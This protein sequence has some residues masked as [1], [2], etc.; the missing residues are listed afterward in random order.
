MVA[1]LAKRVKLGIGKF[2]YGVDFVVVSRFQEHAAQLRLERHH[3][4]QRLQHEKRQHDLDGFRFG[5]DPSG[6]LQQAAQ[7]PQQVDGVLTEGLLPHVTH[8]EADQDQNPRSLS[9][10]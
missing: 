5:L 4:N 3:E 1:F 6:V 10:N 8:N 2:L 7:K 9:S